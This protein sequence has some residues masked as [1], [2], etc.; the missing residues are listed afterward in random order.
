M[1]NALSSA[2]FG[3]ANA[4]RQV[5]ESAEKIALAGTDKV[6]DVDLTEEAVKI[7][8]SEAA[9]KANLA[10]VK[11]VNELTDDLLSVFDKKV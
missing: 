7:S 6:D 2:L 10:T 11:T 4:S 8:L 9:Y 3:L 1:I 5:S